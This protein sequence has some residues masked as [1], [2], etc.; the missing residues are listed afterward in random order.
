MKI[1]QAAQLLILGHG[2]TNGLAGTVTISMFF[3]LLCK[4]GL[5]FKGVPMPN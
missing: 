4:E 2:W 1:R 5:K 3:S